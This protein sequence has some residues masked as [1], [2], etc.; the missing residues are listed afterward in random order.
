MLV[1]TRAKNEAIMIGSE[2]KITVVE[3]RGLK[4]RIG[5]EA[6][7]GVSIHRQEIYLEIQNN[8]AEDG[9]S[10]RPFYVVS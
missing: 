2:V 1:L 3:I 9:L 7:E 6:P 4:V 8:R 10:I 5:I